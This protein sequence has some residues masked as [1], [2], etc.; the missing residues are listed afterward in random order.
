MAI[1]NG[2]EPLKANP[3]QN[4]DNQLKDIISKMPINPD[5]LKTVSGFADGKVA[6]YGKDIIE[7]VKKYV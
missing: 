7:I 1:L 2:E 5:A 6:K 3:G 4:N